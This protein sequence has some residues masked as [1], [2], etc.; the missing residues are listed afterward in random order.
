MGKKPTARFVNG[1]LAIAI[2]AFFAVHGIFG[3]VSAFVDIPRGLAW[4]VWAGVVVVGVHVLASVVTSYQQMADKERPPSPRKKRHLVLKWATGGAL[5]AAAAMHIVDMQMAG[6]SLEGAGATGLVTLL[7][8]IAFV[9]V[10][11]CVGA[12]SLLKDIGADRNRKN[13]VRIA[14]CA[15]C[16]AIA[17]ACIMGLSGKM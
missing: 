13:I 4:L 16:A 8:L 15:V 6:G 2:A 9:A 11:V 3:A 7:A 17:I 14:T 12:R 10:H 5:A 1:V